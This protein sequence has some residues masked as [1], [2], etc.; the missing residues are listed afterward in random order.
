MEDGIKTNTEEETKPSPP[1]NLGQ[2][3]FLY[4][5]ILIVLVVAAFYMGR[6]SAQPK[7]AEANPFAQNP[8]PQPMGTPVPITESDLNMINFTGVSEAKKA[9]VLAKFNSQYCQCNCKMTIV[10]CMVKDLGCPYWMDHVNQFQKALGNGKKP[11]ISRVSKPPAAMP[12]GAPKGYMLP[13]ANSNGFGP[14]S[15]AGK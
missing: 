7:P 1:M 15:A 9:E 10:T 14:P 13:P 5:T 2:K 4:I 3:R 8:T 6:Y 11:R 12:G